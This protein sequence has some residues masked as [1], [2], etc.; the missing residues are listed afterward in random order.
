MTRQ[1]HWQTVWQWLQ[2]QEIED[3]A[4]EV[5]IT[6]LQ[7]LE[8]AGL[9]VKQPLI[10]ES[11]E[12]VAVA[13]L[14]WLPKVNWLCRHKLLVTIG[15]IGNQ[16]TAAP[17]L[18]WLQ[19]TPDP[20]WQ[21]QGLDAWYQ[22]P[23]PKEEQI[24]TVQSLLLW[25]KAPITIRGVLWL[26]VQIGGKEMLRLLAE[27]LSKPTAGIIRDEFLNDAWFRLAQT[28]SPA[29]C[30]AVIAAY[31]AVAVWLKY[32]YWDEQSYY[33]LYPSHDYLWQIAQ[34]EG[35]TQKELKKNYWKPRNKGDLAVKSAGSLADSTKFC[36]KDCEKG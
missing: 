29:S 28:V 20:C 18:A 15:R 8:Q 5:L 2:K 33:G 35:I 26:A 27:F 32:R 22:L 9:Q 36:Q 3:I 25:A 17:L 14:A 21:L 6:K 4:P 10:T 16:E 34:T 13:L 12:V 1:E 31:P 23:L 30:R 7:Q 24:H 11:G 19:Q